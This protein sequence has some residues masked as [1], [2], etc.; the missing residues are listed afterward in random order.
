MD[1]QEQGAPPKRQ[2]NT[3]L[4]PDTPRSLGIANR[5][6]RTGFDFADL[7]SSLMS[8]IISG[9]VTPAVGN[10]ACNAG[11]KLLK[12]VE[13]QYKYGTQGGTAGPRVLHLV[14]P[15]PA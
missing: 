11:G 5:G 13:M 6:I 14:S 12:I 1:Q 4:K 9:R 8:D 10:A 7:M 2:K 15:K 3:I